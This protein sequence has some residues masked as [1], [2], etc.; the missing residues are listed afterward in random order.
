LCCVYLSEQVLGLVE[1]LK[2]LQDRCQRVDRRRHGDVVR[3]VG[4][5]L[6]GQGAAVQVHGIIKLAPL[7]TGVGE[8][9]HRGDGPGVRGPKGLLGQVKGPAEE[10]VGLVK[11]AL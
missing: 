3:T 6:L 4:L 1:L 9:R 5:D 8:V 10:L 7:L 2:P 11:L